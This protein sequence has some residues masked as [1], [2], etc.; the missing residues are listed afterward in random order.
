MVEDK[1]L[2]LTKERQDLVEKHRG[3]WGVIDPQHNKVFASDDLDEAIE[4]F[5]Q[6][7]PGEIPSIFKIPTKEEEMCAYYGVWGSALGDTVLSP[8]CRI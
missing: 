2:W 6:E 4:A 8:S 7:H 5:A 3:Q 1:L